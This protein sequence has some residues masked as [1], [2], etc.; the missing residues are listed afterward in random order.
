MEAIRHHFNRAT[1]LTRR[2]L[3]LAG[4]TPTAVQSISL[5]A[6][7]RDA[8]TAAVSGSATSCRFSLPHPNTTVLVDASA[9]AHVI[10]DIVRNAREAMSDSGQVEVSA[11][12]E[13]LAPGNPGRLP[14]GSYIRVFVSDEGPGIPASSMQHVFEP[15]FT[16]KA[17]SSGLGLTIVQSIVERQGGRVWVNPSVKSGAQVV[18]LLPVG[19]SQT[20]ERP[21]QGSAPCGVRV[22]VMDDEPEVRWVLKESLQRLGY[23]VDL[24]EHGEHAIEV[25][26]TALDA[27]TP[28]QVAILDLTIIDGM[29]GAETMRHL[30]DLN[31]EIRG[32]VCSGYAN[33]PVL[34]TPKDYGFV[35]RLE[36]PYSLDALAETVTS[37]LAPSSAASDSIRGWN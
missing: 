12:L 10:Q 27:G 13:R 7:V 1:A 35:A 33:D 4:R 17:A 36:K 3:R 2:L 8:A 6:L 25:F 5:A 31:A 37:V 18:V 21:G 32:I 29:G 11:T 20:S 28:H 19:Q 30:L 26:Q 24:A 23:E 14:A 16:T 9:L 22:L 34:L 15:Y